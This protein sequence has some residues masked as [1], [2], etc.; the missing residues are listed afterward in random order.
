MPQDACEDQRKAWGLG[1]LVL[2]SALRIITTQNLRLSGL[3]VLPA[4]L[5]HCQHPPLF[6]LHFPNERMKK[7]SNMLV[8]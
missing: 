7:K 6:H 1:V 2:P 4:E 5:C 3:V 8:M